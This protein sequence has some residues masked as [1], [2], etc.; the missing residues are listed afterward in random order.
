MSDNGSYK[1]PAGRPQST[2][3][4]PNQ[5]PAWALE[6]SRVKP[7]IPD[8]SPKPVVEFSK[9][10]RDIISDL[11]AGKTWNAI[12]DVRGGKPE[13]IDR[14]LKKAVENNV[15]VGG[16]KYDPDKLKNF[17]LSSVGH[18]KS[19]RNE[20]RRV[21]KE[22]R[23][24]NETETRGRWVTA[25]MYAQ[26]IGVSSKRGSSRLFRNAIDKKKITKRLSVYLIEETGKE[27]VVN[28]RAPTEVSVV[29]KPPSPAVV[30]NSQPASP[31]H[32]SWWRRIFLFWRNKT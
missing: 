21:E 22:A 7:S 18:L 2:P 10:E 31:N 11:R 4:F 28:R 25:F 16:V 27:P 15:D 14:V 26:E 5:V 32:V 30:V 6:I 24:L 3:P 23:L 17:K 29:R 1:P 20:R 12:I 9:K 8:T 13:D 19:Y